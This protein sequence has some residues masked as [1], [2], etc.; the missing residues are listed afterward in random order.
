MKTVIHEYTSESK[1]E[2]D[3]WV[4]RIRDLKLESVHQDEQGIRSECLF[5]ECDLKA[6]RG[7]IVLILGTSGSGKSLLTQLLL[8]I[9]S[10]LSESL[11]LN[12]DQA[13]KPMMLVHLNEQN[14]SEAHDALSLPYPPALRSKLGVMFQSLGLFE[15]LSVEENF[16]FANLHSSQ[17]RKGLDWSTWMQDRLQGLQLS[18]RVLKKPISTLSGGEKQRVALG[19]LLAYQPNIMI[20]DE[21]S[22]ALDHANTQRTVKMIAEAHSRSKVDLTLVITHDIEAFL[23]IADRVWLLDAQR[24]FKDHAPAWPL[25][26]YYAQLNEQQASRVRNLNTQELDQH[27]A[28]LHDLAFFKLRMLAWN[29]LKQGLRTLKSPWLKVYAFKFLKQHFVYAL[30]FHLGAGFVLGAVATYFAFNLKLGSI[31]LPINESL[32]LSRFIIPTFFEQMLSGFSVVMYRAVIP[33]FT[34]LSFAARSGTA[35]T[36]YLSAMRAPQA[37][38]WEAFETFGLSPKWLFTPPILLSMSLSC[39]LLSYLS[40]WTASLGALLASLVINPLCAYE[41]WF[42]H[43]TRLIDIGHPL[44]FKG[45][46][47][48]ILKTML[49]G[50]IIGLVSAYFGSKTKHSTLDSMTALSRA[51]VVSV[52]LILLVFF[53][54]L[55]LE[56]KGWS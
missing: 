51:N 35:T 7:E 24:H 5:E 48:L 50:V 46:E 25:N 1:Q 53:V 30:P 56:S 49:S 32:E 10:C 43:Y 29:R 27:L 6:K 37:K 33:L 39:V 44:W 36:A 4:I 38:Q 13:Q 2:Q 45:S 31:H 17:P 12:R 14:S 18:S 21:P 3:E 19:R 47:A 41:Q 28:T 20:L 16:A 34:C 9:E 42:Q 52:I 40:F 26:D 55:V 54:I 23:P 8:N 15:D 11:I 22:S